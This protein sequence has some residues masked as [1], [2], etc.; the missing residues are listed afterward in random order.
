MVEL[1]EY[2]RRLDAEGQ[3]IVGVCFGHQIVAAAFG[4]EVT[5]NELGYEIARV[6]MQVLFFFVFKFFQVYNSFVE[7][8]GEKLYL[9]YSH[10][11]IV[12]TV[13][14]GFFFSI[15][16]YTIDSKIQVFLT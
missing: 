14:D 16:S 12:S 6:E 3:F 7:D 10:R 4:G 5:Q 9:L 15:C 1:M 8:L 11:D 13:P 2:I